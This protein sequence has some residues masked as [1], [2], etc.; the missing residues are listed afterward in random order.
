MQLL[1]AWLEYPG[2]DLALMDPHEQ[3]VMRRENRANLLSSHHLTA[4]LDKFSL[5]VTKTQQYRPYSLHVVHKKIKA[6][7]S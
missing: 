7:I 5:A 1:K 4:P 6:Q 3:K 2:P